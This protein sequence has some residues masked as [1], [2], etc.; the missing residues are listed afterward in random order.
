M[1]REGAGVA[2]MGRRGASFWRRTALRADSWR[3]EVGA[4][5]YLTRQIRYGILYLPSVPFE[6]G[7]VLGELPQSEEDRMFGRDDLE[8]GCKEGLYE[9]VGYEEAVEA[10]QGGRIV[11]SAFTVWQGEGDDRR[12]GFV[13]NFKRQSR[14]WPKG[15]IKMETLQSFATQLQGGDTLMFWDIKSGYRHFYLHPRMREF[16]IFRYDFVFY[17]CIALPFGWGQSV[18][19]FTKL[20]RPLVQHLREVLG[21]RVLP[22]IDDFACAPS[23]LGRPST[24]RDCARAGEGWTG[25][26]GAWGWC[27]TRPRDAGRGRRS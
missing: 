23:P 8:R 20:L 24:R 19:W 13:I 12:G 6:E 22:Y 16:F 18:L 21:Y 7:M 9:R 27:D 10:A 3:S 11:S 1:A 25:C 14:H 5:E 26:S 17:R 15:S 2:A 4:S